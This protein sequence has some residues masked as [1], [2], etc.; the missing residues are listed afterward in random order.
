VRSI[1]KRRVRM[2]RRRRRRRRRRSG[3]AAHSAELKRG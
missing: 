3:N 1:Y 2:R